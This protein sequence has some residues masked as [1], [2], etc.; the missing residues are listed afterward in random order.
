MAIAVVES[1]FVSF[2][3]TVAF[4]VNEFLI[5]ENSSSVPPV[6]LVVLSV[7][8]VVLSVGLVVLS[9]GLVVLSVGLVVLSVGLGILKKRT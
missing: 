9:V 7:G 6:G 1:F 8:L 3:P 4:G 2:V 5:V